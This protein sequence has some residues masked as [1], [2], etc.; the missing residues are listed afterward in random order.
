MIGERYRLFNV[1]DKP[2]RVAEQEFYKKGVL[3]VAV[4]DLNLDPGRS[5]VVFVVKR[6]A[7]VR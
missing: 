1:S 6:N 4:R 7:G 3:A 5:T 2:M